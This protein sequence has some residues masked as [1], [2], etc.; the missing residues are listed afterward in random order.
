[1]RKQREGSTDGKTMELSSLLYY[2]ICKVNIM[3][4]YGEYH[5]IVW[6]LLCKC[7]D[8]I[9]QMYGYY[10][11]N[12]RIISCKCMV[13]IKEMYGGNME[14]RRERNPDV[15]VIKIIIFHI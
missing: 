3:E 4:M 8:N 15:K 12:V 14:K 10:Y 13:N 2:G 9:M 1:M 7:M 11:A 6:R 5:T